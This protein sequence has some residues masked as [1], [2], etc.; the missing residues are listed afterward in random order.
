MICYNLIGLYK[1]CILTYLV[2]MIIFA[3]TRQ[4]HRGKQKIQYTY[5]C[6]ANKFLFTVFFR[7]VI[8]NWFGTKIFLHWV[9]VNFNLQT[10]SFVAQRNCIAVEEIIFNMRLLEQHCINSKPQLPSALGSC[11]KACCDTPP[12]NNLY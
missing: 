12:E 10:H 3:I 11:C 9:D 7:R 5:V 2:A 4:K 1:K 6:I 8:I